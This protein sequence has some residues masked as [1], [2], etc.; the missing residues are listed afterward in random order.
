MSK[1]GATIFN[2][3]DLLGRS[4]FYRSSATEISGTVVGVGSY[5]DV[6]K[7]RSYWVPARPLAPSWDQWRALWLV[8]TGRADVLHWPGQE[9]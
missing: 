9:E 8:F 1:R 2:A 7:E 4:E 6:Q 5:G 3:Y